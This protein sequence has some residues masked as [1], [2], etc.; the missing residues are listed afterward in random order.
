MS[1]PTT[2]PVP[3]RRALALASVLLLAAVTLTGCLFD[4]G[5]SGPPEPT[6]TLFGASFQ[7]QD[8]EA[9]DRALA[10]TDDQLDLQVVRVFYPGLPDAWPG[11]A[12]DHDLV[13]SF[14]IDPTEVLAGRHDDAMRDW[15]Q[16]A[17]RDRRIWWVYWHEPE[18]D[19][20]DGSFEPE[21]FR[22]AYAHLSELADEAD[23]PALK[24]TVVLMSYSLDP[25]SGRRWQDWF[26]PADAVDVLAWDVYNR[27]NGDPFYLPP[28]RLFGELQAA[29]LSVGKPYAIAEMASPLAPD[30]DGRDRARWLEEVGCHLVSTDAVF[31]AYFDFLWNDGEDDYRLD[32]TASRQAWRDLG[33]PASDARCPTPEPTS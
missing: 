21:Q 15:F 20:E 4:R 28:E 19:S 2:R 26:P 32:D 8:G 9:Y 33:D 10:R 1:R 16:Q 5:P 12:P 25:D 17:P 22:E 27:G 18:N 23:N 13:V 7:R 14:K 3:R 31:A 24:A 30:D 29:S 11:V 6:R